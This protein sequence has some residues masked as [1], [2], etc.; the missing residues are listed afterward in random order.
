MSPALVASRTSQLQSMT[1]LALQFAKG[2]GKGG[3][4]ATSQGPPDR[5]R[6]LSARPLLARPLS[7]VALDRSRPL[8][9]RPLS[10]WAPVLMAEP[11]RYS[12]EAWEAPKSKVGLQLVKDRARTE[13]WEYPLMD[14]SRRSFV[15]VLRCPFSQSER[16][17]FFEWA[18]DGTSWLQPDSRGIPMPRK[19][20][21]MVSSSCSCQYRYGGVEVPAVEF[22]PWMLRLM[23]LVMPYCGFTKRAEWPDS[24]NLNLYEDGGMSVGWHSDDERLFQGTVQDI[25]IV[26]LSLGME[27]KFELRAN[28]PA[29]GEVSFHNLVLGDGDICTMEGMLQKHYQHRVPKEER[30]DRPRIN[31]TWR[32]V[33]KHNPRCSAD[34]QRLSFDRA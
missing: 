17:A 11:D 19:T 7:L 33:V 23:A 20:A 22:P 3:R 30:I 32:W 31:L 28:W 10:A 27:R 2:R 12:E 29:T 14:E 21:W 5:S 24:C 26:S 18:R 4:F 13:K 8:S 6:P 1:R 15:G 16:Q 9:A 25:C 34:R